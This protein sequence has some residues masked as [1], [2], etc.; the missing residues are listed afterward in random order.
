MYGWTVVPDEGLEAGYIEQLQVVMDAILHKTQ[1]RETIKGRMR[2]P[3]LAVSP[4]RPCCRFP[5]SHFGA[6]ISHPCGSYIS[7]TS[8]P[9]IQRSAEP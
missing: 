5:N 2:A 9:S 3:H 6:W 8:R 4:S 7:P 1:H